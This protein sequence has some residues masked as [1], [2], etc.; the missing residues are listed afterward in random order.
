MTFLSYLLRVDVQF[1]DGYLDLILVKDC[2]FFD[3]LKLMTSMDTGN[4][5]RLP[6]VTYLKV[7]NNKTF[8]IWFSLCFLFDR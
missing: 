6:Y 8:L 2:Q 3:L 7:S 4:H 5:V 1:S